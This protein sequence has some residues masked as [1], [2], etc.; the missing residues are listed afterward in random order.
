MAQEYDFRRF[1]LEHNSPYETADTG[2]RVEVDFAFL[3]GQSVRWVVFD[4][5]VDIFRHGSCAAG[6]NITA[7]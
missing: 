4:E 1:Q 2:D 7:K 6:L 5:K 3:R